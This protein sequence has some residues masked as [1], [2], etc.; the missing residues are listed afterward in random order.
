MGKCTKFPS[1]GDGVV[2]YKYACKKESMPTKEGLYL[3]IIISK[4]L[5]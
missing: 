5:L 3:S 4:A 2:D 1:S